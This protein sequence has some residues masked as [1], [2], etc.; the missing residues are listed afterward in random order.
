MKPPC[1]VTPSAIGS[2]A[3]IVARAVIRIGRS[4]CLPPSTTASTTGRP[5]LRYWLMRSI[6]TIALVTTMPMS[7]SMPIIAGTPMGVP[8]ATS[9]PIAPVAANGMETSR[10]SGWMSERN[11]ATST[12]KTIAM[13]AS[14]ARPSLAKASFWS[15][16]TPPISTVAPLGSVFFTLSILLWRAAETAPVLSPVGLAVIVAARAP[17]IRVI[18]TGP[19]TVLTSAMSPSRTLPAGEPICRFFSWSRVVAGWADFTTTS[20]SVSSR[21]ALPLVV[22]RTACAT[23]CPRLVS[24]KPASAALSL[25]LTE[26]RGTLCERSL[27]TSV[28]W[29]RPAT[30]ERTLSDADL[31][32]FASAAFTTTLRSWSPKP[33][34]AETVVRPMPSSFLRPA[35][36]VSVTASA[37]PESFSLTSYEAWLA[38]VPPPKAAM[39]PD[40]PTVTW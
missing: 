32:V 4:R 10:I 40:E 18:W 25:P 6:S 21:T 39:M 16:E 2:S 14:M 29:S 20:R 28:T 12:M 15:E 27:R 17:S 11:V 31:R 37:L 5:C 30:A 38:P 22:P 26:M 23:V 35:R 7:I 24:V 36:M 34:P 33:P 19:G 1:P 3:K 8:V 9:R 13:A